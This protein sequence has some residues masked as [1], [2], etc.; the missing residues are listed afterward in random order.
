MQV[1]EC[2]SNPVVNYHQ[3]IEILK[4]RFRPQ[5]PMIKQAI[6]FLIDKEYIQRAEDRSTYSYLA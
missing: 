2:A 1:A 6:D 5:V 3:V 4:A